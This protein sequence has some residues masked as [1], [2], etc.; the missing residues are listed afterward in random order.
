MEKDALH[1]NPASRL[2]AGRM[3]AAA[4][5]A[6]LLVLTSA[7]PIATARAQDEARAT[8]LAKKLGSKIKTKSIP[9]SGTDVHGGRSIAVVY[10]PM[11]DVERIVYDYDRYHHF[12]PHL[13]KSKVL[14]RRGSSAIAY[15]EA[16]VLKGAIPPRWAQMR[17]S[18]R[19]G[20]GDTRIIE[21]KMTKG[22]VGTF[23][24][25]WYLTPAYK[26]GATLVAFEMVVDPQLPSFVSGLVETYVKKVTQKT[27]K[28][29]RKR[30]SKAKK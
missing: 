22:N 28:R 1:A 19:S 23:T 17:L 13:T 12:I 16:T 14:A 30:V 15:F 24:A 11:K 18:K 3:C 21:G 26:G 5:F 4:L 8:A 2:Q 20:K 6:A 7:T 29:L 10:A 27:V 9:A 25:R